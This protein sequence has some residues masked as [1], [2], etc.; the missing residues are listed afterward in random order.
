MYAL[1]IDFC[2][3]DNVAS[4]G[5]SMLFLR[6]CV[7]TGVLTTTAQSVFMSNGLCAT[8]CTGTYAY[9]VIIGQRCYCSDDVPAT[10]VPTDQCHD[11]CP[12]YPPD[13]CGNATA[14]YHAYFN[15]GRPASAT[16]QLTTTGSSTSTSTA[17]SI[18]IVAIQQYIQSALSVQS[19]PDATDACFLNAGNT[20][21]TSPSWY[22]NAPTQ[23]QSYFSS[24]HKDTS[25]TCATLADTFFASHPRRGL[26]TG[27]KAGIIVGSILGALLLAGILI[28]VCL[29]LRRHRRRSPEYNSNM[30]E[31]MNEEPAGVAAARM[32][33]QPDNEHSFEHDVDDQS[34]GHG[35]I[36]GH[37]QP[38]HYK[39]ATVTPST[40]APRL[41]EERRPS[42]PFFGSP[43]S[44]TAV[45]AA[46]LA[47]GREH[48]R[49][50]PA[51][52]GPA[53]VEDSVTES[54][55][56]SV[57]ETPYEA[58]QPQEMSSPT[59]IGQHSTIP[60]PP[61]ARTNPAQDLYIL[62]Q[63]NPYQF[64]AVP[65]SSAAAH[66]EK[67]IPRKPVG[68]LKNGRNNGRD[69]ERI[70]ALP[71]LAGQRDSE[72]YTFYNEHGDD[73]DYPFHAR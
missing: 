39:E 21:Y 32:P 70:T 17:T 23:V 18:N 25:A 59:H 14:G 68:I 54:Q 63:Q 57:Y 50:S 29:R 48:S 20:L 34:I 45:A 58:P 43:A 44:R 3:P 30:D 60:E 31:K 69:G 55:G 2:S 36:T 10:Q 67:N 8:R 52:Q 7:D 53:H 64:P 24:T 26:S 38:L 42:S 16:I 37:Q 62:H 35:A 5:P 6:K 65:G 22:Q 72:Q 28:L 4:T 12:G 56:S 41:T 61:P 15:L 13:F 33:T 1:P 49:D 66:H 73:D 46:A 9:A 71:A 40:A 51:Q 27:A 11:P 19:G 47:W